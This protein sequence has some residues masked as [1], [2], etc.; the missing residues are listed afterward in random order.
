MPK[1]SPN[2]TDIAEMAVAAEAAGA[3]AISLINTITGM[4]ID[5]HTKR[6]VLRNNMGGLSGPAVFPVALRMVWQASSAVKIPVIGMGGICKWEDALEMMLA[7][8]SAVQVG[9]AVFANPFVPLKIIDGLN[10]YFDEN[11]ISDCREI[12]GKVRVW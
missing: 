10:S 9:T 1:L 6:P 5:I 8:A 11:H 4:R 7:G 12:I 3:D 2:V